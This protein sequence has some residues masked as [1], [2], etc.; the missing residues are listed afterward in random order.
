MDLVAHYRSHRVG[1]F[2]DRIRGDSMILVKGLDPSLEP[3]GLNCRTVPQLE[4]VRTGVVIEDA[5]GELMPCDV[6]D[7]AG[8]RRGGLVGPAP[9]GDPFEYCAEE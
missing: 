6:Q 9:S 5:I 2:D 1:N 7:R 3:L 4:I 8:D